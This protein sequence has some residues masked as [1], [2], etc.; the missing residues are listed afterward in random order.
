M[1][2]LAVLLAGSGTNLQALLDSEAAGL[3]ARVEVVVSHRADAYGLERAKNAGRTAVYVPFAGRA[4]PARRMGDERRLARLLDAFEPDLIVLAGWMRVLSGE[5]LEHFPNRVIN[6]HPAL[7]P[8]DGSD[9]VS[10]SFGPRPVFRG[11]HA[12][13]D[14][15]KA[16]APVTGASVH[17]ATARPDAGPVILSEEVV[18]RPDDTE[19]SLY[20]RIKR[21]EH[22]LLPR[23]TRMALVQ[24]G[25]VTT[26][27]LNERTGALALAGGR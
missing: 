22:R 23:A 11:A 13:R 20:E 2:R 25:Q 15:L 27:P 24:P 10:T 14:A 19:H 1:K 7:L 8:G 18:I 9:V 16:N 5:W 6:V 3:D 21:V 4:D 26:T 12:V 17:Y